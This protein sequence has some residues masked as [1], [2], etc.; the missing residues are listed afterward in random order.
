MVTIRGVGELLL[1]LVMPSIF[2]NYLVTLFSVV[3][4][5]L[6]VALGLMICL[7][8]TEG[9]GLLLLLPMLQLVGLDIQQ[10]SLGWLPGYVASIFTALGLRPTLISVLSVYVLVISLSAFLIQ[11]QTTINFSIQQEFASCLRKK[12]YWAI[13][14]SH[15]LFF[16]RSRSSDFTYALTAGVKQ[17]AWATNDVFLLMANILV[18]SVYILLA[19]QLSSVM[20]VLVFSSGGALFLL[21]KGKTQIT[22]QA[23]EAVLE[24]TNE[25]YA[26]ATEHLGAMKTAKSYGAVSRN[27]AIFSALTVHLEQKRFDAFT[28]QAEEK[29]WFAIGSVVILSLILYVSLEILGVLT[30]ELLLLLF[31]F[32]R[33]MPKF[34]AIQQSYQSCINLLLAFSHLT[35]MQARC[36]AAAEPEAEW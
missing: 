21:L 36:E 20:T 25:L 29:L 24:A 10:G 13:A 2:W 12:L 5:K 8:L 6:V 4:W 18:T 14:N 1:N 30:G 23:S 3:S 16:S 9:V 22:R 26:A 33:L 11:W 17:V 28:I 31:L 15:W 34:S 32:A 7:S 35:E 27:F 19:L